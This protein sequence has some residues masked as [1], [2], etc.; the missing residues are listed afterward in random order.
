ML[1]LFQKMVFPTPVVWDLT[2]VDYGGQEMSFSN[3]DTEH[4]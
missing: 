1:D 2:E 4:C 3:S